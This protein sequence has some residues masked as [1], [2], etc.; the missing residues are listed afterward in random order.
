MTWNP[1]PVPG[2][3]RAYLD[4]VGGEVAKAS[5]IV[6]YKTKLNFYST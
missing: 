1:S 2:I 6:K 4:R 3:N 5:S